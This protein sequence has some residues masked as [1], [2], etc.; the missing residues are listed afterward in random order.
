MK[1]AFT[2]FVIS[3]LKNPEFSTSIGISLGAIVLYISKEIRE[4]LKSKTKPA[5]ADFLWDYLK[6][7]VDGV[8]DD[9]KAAI[10][11]KNTT[12]DW[13]LS[14][15]KAAMEKLEADWNKHEAEALTTAQK[16]V[17]QAEIVNTMTRAL[18]I[19]TTN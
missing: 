13:K 3:V 1:E 14:V 17:A 9:T 12:D 5:I 11:A 6:P 2:N 18:G 15:I 7:V 16:D 10:A 4:W 8:W 19:T